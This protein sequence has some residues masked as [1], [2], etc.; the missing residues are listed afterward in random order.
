M[1]EAQATE[2]LVGDEM[3][4]SKA[5]IKQRKTKSKTD[6]TA[7][8]KTD[9]ERGF[10][11]VGQFIR[12]AGK[13]GR[14]LVGISGKERK[15]NKLQKLKDKE[16]LARATGKLSVTVDPLTGFKVGPQ[17]DKLAK[18]IKKKEAKIDAKKTR[19]ATKKIKTD[20][21]TKTK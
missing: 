7:S 18:R 15:A 21:K 12:K 6:Q 14:R 2:G 19:K 13:V 1:E 17:A 20:A 3:A 5:E 8:T 4:T 10:G 9:E 11:K 16:K